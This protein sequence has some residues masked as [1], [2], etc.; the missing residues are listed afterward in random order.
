MDNYDSRIVKIFF[1]ICVS[2]STD[3]DDIAKHRF[4]YPDIIDRYIYTFN[5]NNAPLDN[6]Y[7]PDGVENA[8]HTIVFDKDKG[9][10]LCCSYRVKN[11][12]FYDTDKFKAILN[13][14]VDDMDGAMCD[15]WGES[16]MQFQ[17][18]GNV[19]YLHFGNDVEMISMD[20]P[21]T[22]WLHIK[23][24]SID[25]IQ[26]LDWIMNGILVYNSLYKPEYITGTAAYKKKLS[27]S[28]MKDLKKSKLDEKTKA[29]IQAELNDAFPYN[30]DLEAYK[31]ITENKSLFFTA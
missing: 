19:I 1:K 4:I 16:G 11:E 12:L 10:L 7:L 13:K 6:E 8:M 20:I 18:H 26:H 14:I 27:E 25:A 31:Y 15:G 21:N 30:K 29:Q 24:E 23:W 9:I 22:C 28:L 2:D 5:S 17:S 3:I